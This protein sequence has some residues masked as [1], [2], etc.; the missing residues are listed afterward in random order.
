MNDHTQSVA[1]AEELRE[2]VDMLQT[3]SEKVGAARQVKEFS[4][5]RRKNVL[6]K[7]MAPY[8]VQGDS[9]AKAE[10]FAR[11]SEHF[12]SDMEQLEREQQDAESV[13]VSFD[14]AKCR[15]EAR[16]SL[17]SHSRHIQDELQG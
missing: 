2:A 12:I 9:V 7:H 15:Y 16:R 8:L 13:I 3:L 17:L 10:Y 6:A 1:I 4:S 5:D 14:V 11:T